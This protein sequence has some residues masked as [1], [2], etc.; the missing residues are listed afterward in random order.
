MLHH[1]RKRFG[2]HFLHDVGVIQRIIDAIDPRP[3]DRMVEIGPG[4]GAITAPLL[5]H[6]RRLDAIELDRD[7]IPELVR[8]C[9]RAG[10]LTIHQADA[11]NFDFSSLAPDEG[12]LRVV[13]NLPYNIST[14]LIF[15]LL[16]QLSVI[17]DMHF[18]LQREVVERISATP[19]GGAYGRLSIMVQFR[20]RCEVLFSVSGGAF[21]PPPKVESALLRL[22]PHPQPPVKVDDEPR[23]A[24]IVSRAFNQRRKT[25][26]NALKT[27][28]SAKDIEAAGVDPGARPETLTLGDYAALSNI[29][30]QAM[31]LDRGT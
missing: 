23:F 6:V 12:K 3:G 15:H 1:A 24:L 13:G 17:E 4:L 8:L 30:P 16:G 25:L 22:T 31:I 20:C 11:L 5:E 26:K 10:E 27:L 2:Q 19:G 29:G 18:L 21:S 14:P 28:L 7:I 9:A